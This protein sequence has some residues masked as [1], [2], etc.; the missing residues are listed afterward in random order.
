MLAAYVVVEGEH[1][2]CIKS[3]M[4]AHHDDSTTHTLLVGTTHKL[5]VVLR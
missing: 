1:V 2:T 5:L 3:G 4:K